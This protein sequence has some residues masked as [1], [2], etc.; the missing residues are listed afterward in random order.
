MGQRKP[1]AWTDES[2]AKLAA[3]MRKK[4]ATDHVFRE[5]QSEVLRAAARRQSV[6]IEPRPCPKCG[7]THT[8]RGRYCSRK[9]ANTR[10]IS[11][12]VREKIAAS[13]KRAVEEGRLPR[14]G[15]RGPYRH[16][17]EARAKISAASRRRAAAGELKN[18]G[19]KTWWTPA[20]ASA[21]RK[22]QI[23]HEEEQAN[24]LRADGYE[25][26]NPTVV[27]DRIAIKD[28]RVYFVEFKMEGQ[29]L[30]SGQRRVQQ[31]EPDRYIVIYA[32]VAHS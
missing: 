26:F 9:C 22:R 16:S 5:Q 4:W 20:Q 31:T 23:A 14:P 10:E 7:E 19:I 29:E 25:V 12:A 6:P 32:P 15:K 8:K 24:K 2:R 13:V 3:T 18:A 11:S 21:L 27:C 1:R 30:R 28:G 17:A